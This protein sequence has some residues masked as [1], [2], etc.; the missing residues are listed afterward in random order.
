LRMCGL[1]VYR[2]LSPLL[3]SIKLLLLLTFAIKS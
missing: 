1:R 2:P 3:S